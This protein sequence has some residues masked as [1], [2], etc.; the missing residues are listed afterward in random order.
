MKLKTFLFSI[1]IFLVLFTILI[2]AQTSGTPNQIQ[3]KTDANSSLLVATAAQTSPISQPG[4]FSNT[5][6]KTDSNGNLLVV[7]FLTA[8]SGTQQYKS[9]GAIYYQFVNTANTADTNF[10]SSTAYS[11][12]ANTLNSTGDVIQVDFYALLSAAVSTKTWICNI[13]YTAWTAAGG[14]TG[15]VTLLTDASTT[16]SVSILAHSLA[17]KVSSGNVSIQAWS[18]FSNGTSRSHA[19]WSSSALTLTGANNILCEAKDGTGNAA[20]ITIKEMRIIFI[21]AP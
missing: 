20:A 12:P 1:L 13:G 4:V 6:L 9:S 18:Q 19:A 8:G 21:P 11:L 2:L 5:R 16:A 3:V 10:I 15:G 17:T 14:F 7:P